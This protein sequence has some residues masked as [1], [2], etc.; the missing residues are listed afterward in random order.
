[1]AS[2]KKKFGKKRQFLNPKEG[3]AA[4]FYE[5]GVTDSVGVQKGWPTLDHESNLQLSDCS[6]KIELEF[7]LWLEDDKVD[8]LRHIKDRRAKLQRL[9]EVV[10]GFVEATNASY[11]Y[12]ESK[13]DEYYAARKAYEASRKKNKKK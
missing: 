5:V 8:C 13:L 7:N 9:Q 12:I 2:K 10:N 3:V 11:D 6:R 1:M 4:A